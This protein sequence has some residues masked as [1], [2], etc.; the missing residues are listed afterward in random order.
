MTLEEIK[1]WRRAER[2]RLLAARIALSRET[3]AANRAVMDCHL[4]RAFPNLARGV[5]AFCWPYQN[6][7]DARFIARTLR[8]RGAVTALPVVVAPRTPL[9]FRAWH[10]GVTLQRGV[11]DIPYPTE[12]PEATPDTVLLPMLGFDEAG[13]RLGYGGGYFDRTLAALQRRPVV[14]GTTYEMARLETIYPQPHDIPMDWVVTE[15]G[16]YRRDE[17]RLAFLGAPPG[18]TGSALSSPVCYASEFDDPSGQE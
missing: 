6:E 11:Y 10:P 3:V 4:L 13:Y 9:I 8:E 2:T 18:G 14:I 16:V 17:D 15:R 5:V 7:H 1:A 12:G